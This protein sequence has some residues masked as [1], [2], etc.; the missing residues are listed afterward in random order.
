MKFFLLTMQ[1]FGLRHEHI[2]VIEAENLEHAIAIT[3]FKVVSNK[4]RTSALGL[5]RNYND[6]EV[7]E[8]WEISK[9]SS[10]ADIR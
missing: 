7:Y 6:D 10:P 2:G 8:L 9:I 5:Q 4:L 1:G 3:G